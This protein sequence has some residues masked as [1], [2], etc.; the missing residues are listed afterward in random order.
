MLAMLSGGNRTRNETLQAFLLY[1]VSVLEALQEV[2]SVGQY[3]H[4]VVNGAQL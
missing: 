1:S 4:A 3:Q 2:R